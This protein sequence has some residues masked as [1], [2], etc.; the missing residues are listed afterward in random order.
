MTNSWN[1]IAVTREGTTVRIFING[2]SLTISNTGSGVGSYD[3]NNSSGYL[4][5]GEGASFSPASGY[6]SDV[7]IIKGT[8]IFLKSDILN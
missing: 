6:I 4:Y 2:V 5:I 8:V 1:H 3:F 7:R